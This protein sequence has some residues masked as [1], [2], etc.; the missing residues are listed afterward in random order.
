MKK[1]KVKSAI[2]QI[3]GRLSKLCSIL[4]TKIDEI[5]EESVGTID[6]GTFSREHLIIDPDHYDEHVCAQPALVTFWSCKK[7]EVAAITN[8]LQD[9]FDSWEKRVYGSVAKELASEND[10]EMP[11]IPEIKSGIEKKYSKVRKEKRNKIARWKKNL[12]YLES[13]CDGL[14]QKSFSL[15]QIE[16]TIK[17]E[18]FS[19]DSK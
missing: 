6:I 9:D 19:T 2:N 18:R 10:G 11:T 16:S 8:E 3:D 7:N 4:G 15:S 17:E 13:I 5:G 1:K 12:S 14:R